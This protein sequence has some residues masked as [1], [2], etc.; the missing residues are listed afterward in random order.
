[1]NCLLLTNLNR[2]RGKAKGVRVLTAETTSVYWS[3]CGPGTFGQSLVVNRG[4]MFEELRHGT[5]GTSQEFGGIKELQGA[6]FPFESLQSHAGTNPHVINR[7]ASGRTL[8]VSSGDSDLYIPLL[9]RMHYLC[10]LA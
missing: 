6:F 10:T 3:V 7:R 1:M 4:C 8:S 2:K 9:L 5:Y